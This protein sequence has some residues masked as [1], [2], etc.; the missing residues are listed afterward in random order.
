M[1]PPLFR[2]LGMYPQFFYILHIM[3]NRQKKALGWVGTIAEG[4]KM[5]TGKKL[6]RA[7]NERAVGAVV[8]S[9]AKGGLVKKTGLA[10]VH[11]GET[12]LSVAQKKELKKM[13]H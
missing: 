6:G 10:K 4:A 11:K 13:L 12:V 3:V 7:L 5:V 1:N 8:G 9:Y 2:G